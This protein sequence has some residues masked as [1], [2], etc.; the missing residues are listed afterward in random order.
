MAIN[1]AALAFGLLAT[2]SS[3]A[4][5]V[6]TQATQNMSCSAGVCSATA[7]KAYL[8]VNDVTAML[9][10]GDL[11]VATGSRTEDIHVE[12]PF[13]WTSNSSLTLDAQRSISI[14][15]RITVGGAG[16]LILRTKD[17]ASA[18]TLSFSNSGRIKFR[19]PSSSFSLNGQT[20]RLVISVKD[21]AAAVGVNPGGFFALADNYDASVDGPYAGSPIANT[22]TGRLEGLGNTVTNLSITTG[23]HRRAGDRAMFQHIGPGGSITNFNLLNV[24]VSGT[25]RSQ[26]EA[27]LAAQNEG[28]ISRTT[29]NGSVVAGRAAYAAGGVV[30]YNFGEI[31]DVRSDV[32]VRVPAGGNV[33]RAGGIAGENAGT[34]SNSSSAG[35]VS[36]TRCADF[37]DNISDLGGLVGTNEG[38]ISGSYSVAGVGACNNSSGGLVSENDGTIVNS[39]A[40]GS[41]GAGNAGSAGG[42]VV[43]GSAQGSTLMN[44]YSTASVFPTQATVGGLVGYDGGATN[45]NCYWDLDTSGITD[46]A[47]GAYSPRN[48]PGLVGLSDAQL[49]S[50][51][52]AG[53]DPAVWGQNPN[54][55]NGYPYLLANPPRRGN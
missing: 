54:I 29:V 16:A 12:A 46:P 35:V 53:F 45:A 39:Y 28:K 38:T 36:A 27:G 11:K 23:G 6:S 52:P 17:G 15:K 21:L 33:H 44:V 19:D 34:I 18:G 24:T 51:L 50:G 40:S 2:A 48:D 13:S 9:A 30:A 25:N 42:G 26:Y 43:A 22:F 7:Q 4:I 32:Y 3:A 49:K 10:A 31:T 55:N 1:A 14:E 37:N 8:N 41:V 20:Y 5:N 47:Q